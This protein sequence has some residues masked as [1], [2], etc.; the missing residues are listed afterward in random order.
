MVPQTVS[1]CSS[2]GSKHATLKA[3]VRVECRRRSLL[4]R[5]GDR[6]RVT[7]AIVIKL[8]LGFA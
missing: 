6:H 3:G 4:A 7:P 8:A 5:P 1:A 2:T